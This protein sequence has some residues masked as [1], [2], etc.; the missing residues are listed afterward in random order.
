MND[1]DD[2]YSIPQAAK[3]CSISRVTLWRWVKSGKL[4]TF[5]TPGGHH[6]I[7]K[8][9]LELFMN[10]NR[11]DLQSEQ[12]PQERRILLVDDDPKIKALV[13]K[14]LSAE[15][16][17]IEEASDGFEAG[18]KLMQINPELIILDLHMPK[19]DGF[20][21]CRQI[22]QD[23]DKAAIKVLILT[24]FDTR[25]NKDRVMQLGA[26]GYL[27]KPARKQTLLQEIHRLLD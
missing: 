4:K 8:Q 5:I 19:M 18:I 22:K 14:M 1:N 27:A 2:I 17:Q 13:K 24:G 10:G 6:R 21:V 7:R 26:D 11:M 20:E 25:E 9:D 16:F 12:A 3:Y 15:N 23:P